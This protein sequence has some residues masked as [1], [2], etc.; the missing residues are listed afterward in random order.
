LAFALITFVGEVPAL[1]GTTALLL[2]CVFT[3]VNIAVLVLRKDTV[4]HKHFRT[5]TWLAIAGAICCA[6]LAGPWTG[7]DPVQYKIAGILIGIGVVL[8]VITVLINRA[9]GVK[10]AD[11]L[12]EDIGGPGPVN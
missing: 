11:P 3:V 7:R 1:G 12:A 6:F 2:L 10:P 5:P 9:Q 8:W 4:K